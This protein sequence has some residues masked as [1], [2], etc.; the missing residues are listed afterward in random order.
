MEL[1]IRKASKRFG[2][3]E[4]FKN[5]NLDLKKGE[6]VGLF[7]RNGSGKS[8]LLKMIFGLLVGDSLEIQLEDR[9]LPVQDVIPKKIISYLPQGRFLPMGMKVREIVS[10]SFTDGETLDK[11]FYSPSMA[12]IEKRRYGELSEG[13]KKY[14][15]ILLI[16]HLSHPF[17]MLDEPFSMVDP[18][19]A[20]IIKEL[21][22]NLKNTKGII[23]TDHYYRDVLQISDRNY[24]INDGQICTVEGAEELKGLGYLS[25]RM[26]TRK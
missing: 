13:E 15:E 8:T 9:V 10:M 17:M 5:I 3:K 26:R 12:E 18:K 7:G 6:I 21:L 1:K 19:N 11:I 16:A 22:Q 2:N 4:I 23:I 20:E 14:I 24:L 25:S